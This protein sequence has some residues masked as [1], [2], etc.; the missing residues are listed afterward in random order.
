MRAAPEAVEQLGLVG[1]DAR[2]DLG[3]NHLRLD[4]VRHA[5]AQ[6]VQDHIAGFD[7]RR[8]VEG[9]HLE[10][11]EL[12][13][14]DLRTRAGF[15]GLHGDIH[16]P[17]DF[18][19]RRHLDVQGRHALGRQVALGDRPDE[20]GELGLHAVQVT[21]AAQGKCISHVYFSFLPA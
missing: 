10:H 13:F 6:A 1:V 9:M 5:Q 21:I 11:A 15:G 12:A 2:D 16:H 19:A 20:G 3:G 17:E 7:D 18:V 4:A 8:L 14:D